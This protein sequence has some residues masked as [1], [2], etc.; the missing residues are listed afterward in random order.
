MKITG[1]APPLIERFRY[2]RVEIGN[3]LPGP[4]NG[5]TPIPNRPGIGVQRPRDAPGRLPERHARS[6]C[7]R[8]RTVPSREV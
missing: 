4:V 3:G 5:F 7:G 8:T 1:V 6:G 2:V